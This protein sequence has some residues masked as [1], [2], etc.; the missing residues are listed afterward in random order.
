[1]FVCVKFVSTTADIV[2][3]PRTTTTSLRGDDDLRWHRSVQ[4][5]ILAGA[6]SLRSSVHFMYAAVASRP[7]AT[8]Y[9]KRLTVLLFVSDSAV[10][11]A[12]AAASIVAVK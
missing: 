7:T 8:I 11:A 10:A 9:S 2:N 6:V 5:S 1:M 4:C 12:V 3:Y